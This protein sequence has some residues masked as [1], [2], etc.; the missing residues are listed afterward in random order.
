MG[1]KIHKVLG[2]GVIYP[3]AEELF[4]FL[5]DSST[6]NDNEV[7]DLITEY[8][9][10]HT[11]KTD[12]HDNLFLETK[13]MAEKYN[14]PYPKHVMDCIKHTEYEVST[15][16]HIVIIPP[17]WIKYWYRWDD[18]IDYCEADTEDTTTKVKFLDRP[19]H[20]YSTWIDSVTFETIN[21]EDYYGLRRYQEPKP[22]PGIPTSVR[23][24]ADYINLDWKTLRPMVVTWWS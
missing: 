22:I 13:E 14:T 21:H 2:Y 17:I 6:H 15:E 18:N 8:L 10:T 5:D 16:G 24:I 1:F 4:E 7:D 19:I 20:P 11:R 3:N 23:L 9:K 12:Y